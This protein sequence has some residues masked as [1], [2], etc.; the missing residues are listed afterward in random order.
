MTVKELQTVLE[1]VPDYKM[2]RWGSV[3]PDFP[4][5]AYKK[6]PRA[7]VGDFKQWL[8]TLTQSHLQLEDQDEGHRITVVQWLE[9]KNSITLY[10]GTA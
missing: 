6:Y 10:I 8:D 5:S 7:T 3:D 2:L 9:G 1:T 4:E